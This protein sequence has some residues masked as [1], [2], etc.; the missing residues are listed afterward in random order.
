[1]MIISLSNPCHFASDI[2][3]FQS[4]SNYAER[5]PTVKNCGNLQLEEEKKFFCILLYCSVDK[6]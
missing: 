5:S 4:K 6:V 3:I 2:V 1:M